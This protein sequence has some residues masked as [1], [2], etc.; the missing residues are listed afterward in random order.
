M[1]EENT[2]KEQ[3]KWVKTHLEGGDAICQ[4]SWTLELARRFESTWND[5]GEDWKWAKDL[6]LRGRGIYSYTLG[7]WVTWC[8]N[9]I[10]EEERHQNGKIPLKQHILSSDTLP[11]VAGASA[12]GTA[13]RG[14]LLDGMVLCGCPA[15]R[16]DSRD[17]HSDT[18]RRGLLTWFFRRYPA[19]RGDLRGWYSDTRES[20][21]RRFVFNSRNS[22]SVDFWFY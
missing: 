13:T 18:R 12:P 19:C 5:L 20:R 11:R 14:N 8:L 16:G 9:P 1:E 2:R 21:K 10:G 22:R 4:S 6:G 15:G 7:F 3:E 17:W